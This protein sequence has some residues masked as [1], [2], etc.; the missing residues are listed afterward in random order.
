MSDR[1]AKI[2]FF[3]LGGLQESLTKTDCSADGSDGVK[4]GNKSDA[5]WA[6]GVFNQRDV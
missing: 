4:G 1:A 2:A 6:G 5:L 3:G